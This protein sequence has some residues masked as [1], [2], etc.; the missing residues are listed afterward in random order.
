MR[1]SS[2][3]PSDIVNSTGFF[4]VISFCAALIIWERFMLVDTKSRVRHATTEMELNAAC[5]EWFFEKLEDCP[6]CIPMLDHI[7]EYLELEPGWK[8]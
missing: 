1:L 7:A 5:L 3:T 2:V 4:F 8:G 6:S